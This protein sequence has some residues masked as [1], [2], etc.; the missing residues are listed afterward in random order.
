MSRLPR[1]DAPGLI[2]HVTARGIEE[3]SIF[4]NDE[5]RKDFLY[6]L[7]SILGE[8]GAR[9]YAWSLLPDHFHLLLDTAKTTL[10]DIMRRLMTG[11]AMTYNRRHNRNGHLFQN[12]Y[13]S[14]VCEKDPYLLELV[15]YIHLNPLRDGLVKDIPE[16]D[17][18][19]WSGHSALMGD[20]ARDW[21]EVGG[22]LGYFS[23]TGARARLGYRRFIEDGKDQGRRPELEGEGRGRKEEQGFYD[24]RVLGGREFAEKILKK[25]NKPPGQEVRI[26]LPDLIGRIS[27]RLG[28]EEDDLLLG[29]RKKEICQARALICYLATRKMGYRFSEVGEALRIHPVNVARSLERGK[30]AFES[31]KLRIWKSEFSHRRARTKANVFSLADLGQAKTSSGHPES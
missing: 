5:D 26:P 21:Q 27:D 19:P 23:D 28:M 1:L 20:H 11:Y 31:Q 4:R 6:R 3:Q 22:V 16:L 24:E 10:S 12:R 17:Q 29:R 25:N 9:C 8:M 15:R 2:H 7:G 30:E 14:I 13:K 18:Y